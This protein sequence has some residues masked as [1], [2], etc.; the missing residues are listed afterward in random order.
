MICEISVKDCKSC[1]FMAIHINS[2]KKSCMTIMTCNHPK[3]LE[4]EN[5]PFP[6]EDS[7]IP[8]FCP[9]VKFETLVTVNMM[10]G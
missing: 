1:P 6:V 10:E 3:I 5:I 8:A 9:L 2:N 7:N 4:M